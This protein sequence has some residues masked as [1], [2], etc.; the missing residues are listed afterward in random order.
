VRGRALAWHFVV[1]VMLVACDGGAE[2][3]ATSSRPSPSAS[4][5]RDGTQVWVGSGAV[6]V[7][8]TVATA[9]D[10]RIE[11]VDGQVLQRVGHLFRCKRE[12]T[13]KR[14]ILDCGNRREPLLPG[15]RICSG[16]YR[17]PDGSLWGV[18][19]FTGPEVACSARGFHLPE[20]AG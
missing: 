13:N 18:K 7:A 5:A 14:P 10:D 11:F 1:A 8:G 16:G 4:A 12:T 17:D 3:P 15:E 2:R 9:S 20:V 6:W 19:I